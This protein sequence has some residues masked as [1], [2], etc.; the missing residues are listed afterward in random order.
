MTDPQLRRRLTWIHG[1]GM[2]I[3]SVLGSGVLILPAVTAQA[4]GP[5]SILSWLI[6]SAL[7]FPM[8]I[9]LGNL[10]AR[11]PHAGG[12]V[13]YARLAFG[14]AMGRVTAWLFLG[15][16][17]IGVPIIALIGARY[18]VGTLGM[19]SGM[20]PILAGAMLLVSWV[21]HRQG[22][23]M[24]SW[25]Q[26][27]IL[28]L[29]AALIVAAIFA[30]GSHVRLA[31]FYPVVPHGWLPA[32]KSAIEIFWCFLGW[33]MVGH[34]AEE[35][36]HPE[37]DLRRTFV[38]APTL[39]GVLYMALSV[40]TV[41]THSYGAATHGAPLSQLVG[42]GLGHAGSMI[43]G[44]LALL[45]TMVAIH[46][47]VA[48]FSRMVYSQARAGVFPRWLGRVH[49]RRGTPT[50]ALTALMVDFAVVPAVYSLTRVD[51]GTLITWPSTVF[52]V[53]YIIAMASAYKLVA[54]TRLGRVL[55]LLPII[56][57]GALLPFA[58]WAVIYP[59]CLGGVGWMMARVQKSSAVSVS[60]SHN[61]HS[62]LNR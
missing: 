36:R 25:L 8:A 52:L 57:C 34:L 51:L 28:V 59:V 21:M 60:E 7:A 12:I 35:F 40:V 5:A 11:H 30:A 42:L 38:M 50:A 58:G 43:T 24:A 23:A 1:T 37:R 47:N 26:V 6:M 33:E 4:A 29:I 2:A 55:P 27:L 49:P 13:E 22:L 15:T 41:G 62:S 10:G 45:I 46:G 56:V 44:A 61:S 48:G 9:T 32:A 17:P 16:I 18:V 19:P 3:G 31:N 54:G 20:V 39:V 14:E 53:V